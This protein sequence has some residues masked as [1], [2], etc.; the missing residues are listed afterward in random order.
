MKKNKLTVEHNYEF[1]LLGFVAPIKDYKMAWVI[2][3]CMDINLVR[4]KDFELDFL[5][6][7]PIKIPQFMLTKEHGFIQLLRNRS[8]QEGEDIPYLI[9]EL[10][11][12][13]YFLLLQDFT[14]ELNINTYIERLSNCKFI[15]NVVKL[16]ISKIKSKENLL[17]Y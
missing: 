3:D 2:N 7:P 12:M 6:Q 10:R 11:I 9:P 4:I 15:H 17:T 16:D 5:N 13:D 8:Y 14:F 1:E